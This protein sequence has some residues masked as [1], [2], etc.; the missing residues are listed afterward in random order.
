MNSSGMISGTLELS[1][2]YPFYIHNCN[3]KNEMEAKIFFLYS[4]N[5]KIVIQSLKTLSECWL[6]V[7]SML[8]SSFVDSS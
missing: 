6:F 5:P 4:Q 8:T 2:C 1:F 3:K 7:N